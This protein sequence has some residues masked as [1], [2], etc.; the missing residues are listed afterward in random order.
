MLGVKERTETYLF[1]LVKARLGFENDV[2]EPFLQGEIQCS[3]TLFSLASCFLLELMSYNILGVV[4]DKD[5]LLSRDYLNSRL[6]TKQ[7]FQK[8]VA[9][10]LPND[11]LKLA[12][13]VVTILI[14]EQNFIQLI[15]SI[16][17]LKDIKTFK[18]FELCF[19]KNLTLNVF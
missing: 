8:V 11:T 2:M 15:L 6:K 14:S 17:F 12:I 3:D 19:K 1:G 7:I 16:L 4:R 10:V 13:I 9:V 18:L 5:I